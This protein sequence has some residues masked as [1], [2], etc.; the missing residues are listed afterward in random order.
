MVFETVQEEMARRSNLEH[1]GDIFRRI[2]WN[3]RG[4]KSTVWRCV[5]RVEKDGPDCPARN[6]HEETIDEQMQ[7]LQQEL[8]ATA[9]LKDTGDELGMEIRRMRDEKIALQKE[10]ASQK[11]LKARINEMLSFLD[12][13]PCELT[14]Y[15][16]EYVRA[17]LEKI[18]VYD[19]YF[20]VEFKSG[21]EIE[22]EE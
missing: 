2:K 11:D 5:S 18:R 20:I 3:N 13:L 15:K 4:V 19:E 12:D 22:I 17:L 10:Q 8:L 9:N 1:C 7:T 21:I 6:V 16:E 14:E